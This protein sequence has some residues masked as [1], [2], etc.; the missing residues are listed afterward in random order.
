MINEPSI[1]TRLCRYRLVGSPRCHGDR[2][3][4]RHNQDVGITDVVVVD[5]L[6]GFGRPGVGL[7]ESVTEDRFDAAVAAA[8]DGEGPCGG[9]FQAGVAVALGQWSPMQER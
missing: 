8:V 5:G 1:A 7:V 2:R 4:T 3:S 9:R 6:G